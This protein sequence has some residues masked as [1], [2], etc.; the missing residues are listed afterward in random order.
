MAMGTALG[1]TPIIRRPQQAQAGQ[2]VFGP[3]AQ[4]QSMSPQRT[5]GVVN[6]AAGREQ[7]RLDNARLRENGPNGIWTRLREDINRVRN[8][9]PNRP[10]TGNAPTGGYVPTEENPLNAPGKN[11]PPGYMDPRDPRYQS[12]INAGKPAYGMPAGWHNWDARGLE[13]YWRQ[14]SGPAGEFPHSSRREAL[15]WMVGALDQYHPGWRDVHQ[16]VFGNRG[17]QAGTAPTQV[18]SPAQASGF[19]SIDDFRKAASMGGLNGVIA[20]QNLLGRAGLSPDELSYVT[21]AAQQFFPPGAMPA[22][23]GGAWGPY[24]RHLIAGGLSDDELRAAML[25]AKGRI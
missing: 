6:P 14:H 12:W 5:Q 1:R 15:P 24:K 7:Q 23:V 18:Q 8:G 21:Q 4:A 20:A 10:R 9:G 22:E 13:N 11:G 25:L 17:P 19:P 2:A 16:R 3:A